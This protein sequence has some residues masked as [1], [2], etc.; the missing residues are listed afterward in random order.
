MEQ[1]YSPKIFSRMNFFKMRVIFLIAIM[2]GSAISPQAADAAN[3][4]GSSP[5][6]PPAQNEIPEKNNGWQRIP[7]NATDEFGQSMNY[8]IYQIEGVEGVALAPVPEVIRDDLIEEIALSNSD[9]TVSFS[10]NASIIDEIERSIAQGAPTQALIEYANQ[11]SGA[12]GGGQQQEQRGPFGSCKD[13]DFTKEKRLQYTPNFS[14]KKDFGGG[15]SGSIEAQG[16]G[17]L[18]ANGQIKLR[19][20]R[21]RVFWICVPYG[22]R[23]Q[24][25]RIV[26]N[27]TL[28]SMLSVSGTINYENPK[29]IEYEIAKPFLT[30]VAFSI[31]PVPVYI[32]FNLPITVGLKIRANVTGQVQYRGSNHIV[33]SLDYLCTSDNCTGYQNLQTTW[34]NIHNPVG[35]G[36]SGHISPVL[37]ADIGV[38]GFLYSEELVYVQVGFRG[39]LHG[40]LW[41]Y[42]GNACG[43]AEQDGHYE[44]VRALTFDLDWQIAI[45]AKGDTLFTKPKWWTLWKSKQWHISF[46]DLL[47]SSAITPMIQ[48]PQVVSANVGASYNLRMR[49]CWPYSENIDYT[50]SW[51]DGTSSNHIG[52]PAP[53]SWQPTSASHLWT[54]AGPITMQLSALRD[55]HGRSFGEGRPTERE[56]IV[57]DTVPPT[58]LARDALALASSTYCST[59]GTEDCYDTSR[60]NDGDT[61]TTLGGFNSWTNDYGAAMPQWLELQWG[62]V[63]TVSRIDLYT[64]QGYPI[65]DYDIEYWNGTDWVKA[66]SIRSNI[67]LS[68]SDPITP[69]QT[70]RLRVLTFAGPAHQAGYTRINELEVY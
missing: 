27:I 17:Y 21:T 69:V 61:S 70:F 44:T 41:G 39:Y 42:Y 49:P 22:V 7:F 14:R 8:E 45:T 68:R 56:I 24:H 4:S 3:P 40:D 9:E 28:D 37:Y 18:D 33:G 64:S 67:A 53:P 47:D 65:S 57:S 26:G 35:A 6:H 50:M 48:G 11:D 43:D 32:G 25:L 30:G 16:A 59:P 60:T 55:S 13:G 31:G 20:K 19:V 23:F 15:F 58:N 5:A 12:G 2:L 1:Y 38:R 66:A 10:L 63:I 34:Q 46:W 51:G 54:Q 62:R 36:I 52:P 29:P